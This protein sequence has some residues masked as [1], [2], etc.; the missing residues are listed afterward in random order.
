[1]FWYRG[2]SL[3]GKLCLSLLWVLVLLTFSYPDLML[4]WIVTNDY[5]FKDKLLELGK[6]RSGLIINLGLIFMLFVDYMITIIVKDKDVFKHGKVPA[7]VFVY[8]V[9]SF[10][11]A[12]ALNI[13]CE[14]IHSKQILEFVDISIIFII[15]CAG[16]LFIKGESISNDRVLSDKILPSPMV[17]STI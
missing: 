3:L 9:I 14:K 10:F 2:W 16:L 11:I 7:K 12:F 17:R 13:C 8:F 6:E 4:G 1:M 15:F 5:V